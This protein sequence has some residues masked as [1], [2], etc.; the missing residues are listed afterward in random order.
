MRSKLF[1]LFII[2][3]SYAQ[4]Q[5]RVLNTS[6]RNP[7]IKELYIGI[8]NEIEIKG[9]S[10][11]SN[12]KISKSPNINVFQKDSAR[13]EIMTKGL[14]RSS[15]GLDTIKIYQNKKLLKTELYKSC[16]IPDPYL[17]FG[18]TYQNK[19]FVNEIIADP[20]LR[21][22]FPG[23]LILKFQIINFNLIILNEKNGEQTDFK[24]TNGYN[25]NSQQITEIKK[26]KKG[27]KL[28]FEN[29]RVLFPDRTT[30]SMPTYI[31]TVL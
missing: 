3:S 17:R 20:S 11:L 22:I 8:P 2:L 10:D 5:I 28:R 15:N 23:N 31:I 25:L 21:V 14:Y 29:V 27:S 30:R 4:A 7:E 19:A 6:L 16:L 13:F 12:L 24:T 9:I 18:T 1:L 26:L